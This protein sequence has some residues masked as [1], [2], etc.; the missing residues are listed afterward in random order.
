[1]E[2]FIRK[3]FVDP[4]ML[5]MGH[6][7]RAE[8]MN[9]G[10]GWLYYSMVRIIRPEQVVVIGSY[11][12]FVPLIMAKALLDNGGAG[13][14]CFIDPSLAD[15]FWMDAEAVRRHFI[16]YGI[17][18]VLHHRCTTQEFITTESYSALSE[19]GLLM[20]D[21][22]HTAEQ[23]RFDYLAFLEKLSDA[24]VVMFHDSIYP[25]HSP[26][27]DRENPYRHTVYQF[28]ERLRETPGIDL[29]SLPFDSGLTLV[30]GR[31]AFLDFI[32]APFP[33]PQA[34]GL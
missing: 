15:G 11:R 12:G 17:S 26:I 34:A 28:M 18:N 29:F 27:Y 9:L 30:R 21:G 25:R 31:P 7:Q 2:D 23:A 5:R 1:M 16:A 8:D 22:Y 3:L 33:S 6:H 24:A 32:N 14:V 4:N 20:V 10:L 13:K 19:V